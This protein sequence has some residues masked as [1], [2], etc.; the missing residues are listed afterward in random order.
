MATKKKDSI[1]KGTIRK[2][3]DGIKYFYMGNGVWGEIMTGPKAQAKSK[4]TTRPA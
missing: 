2:G 1:R 3:S 4:K